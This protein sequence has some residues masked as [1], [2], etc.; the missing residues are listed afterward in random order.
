MIYI[1]IEKDIGI[2][3]GDSYEEWPVREEGEMVL[4]SRV[5]IPLK[6]QH[7]LR[8][9]IVV[10]DGKFY[11]WKNRYGATGEFTP[12]KEERQMLVEILV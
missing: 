11:N 8:R 6:L 4:H 3:T 9:I 1:D 7:S 2:V 5:K 12:T 10:K